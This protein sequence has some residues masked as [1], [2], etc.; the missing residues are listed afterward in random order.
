MKL[1]RK[2][3]IKNLLRYLEVHKLN[4]FCISKKLMI[5]FFENQNFRISESHENS[6]LEPNGLQYGPSGYKTTARNPDL[7]SDSPRIEK[8]MDQLKKPARPW[9]WCE[10]LRNP[11]VSSNFPGFLLIASTVHPFIGATKMGPNKWDSGIIRNHA[12]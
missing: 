1:L 12:K 4:C 8:S 3:I 5:L 10:N 9:I 6:T 2:S 7:P 11:R